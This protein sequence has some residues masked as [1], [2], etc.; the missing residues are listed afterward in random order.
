MSKYIEKYFPGTKFKEGDIYIGKRG[1]GIIKNTSHFLGCYI[2]YKPFNEKED[3]NHKQNELRIVN[4]H[5]K[6]GELW[7]DSNVVIL[8]Q[9]GR[10]L[11][12]IALS[13]DLINK[14]KKLQAQTPELNSEENK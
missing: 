9:A 13:Q 14:C 10:K 8:R 12:V 1:S 3:T 7:S 5:S 2:S 4:L 11:E 6:K